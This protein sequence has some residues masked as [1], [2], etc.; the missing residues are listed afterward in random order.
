VSNAVGKALYDWL[1][2]VLQESDPWLSDIDLSAGDKWFAQITRQVREA[3]LGVFCLTS[4]NVKSPWVLFEAGAVMA[5][6]GAKVVPYL[7]HLDMGALHGSPLSEFQAVLADRAGTLKLVGSINAC[8]TNQLDTQRLAEVFEKWWP[9][10]EE[11]LSRITS[12]VREAGLVA[13]PAARRPLHEVMRLASKS[14]LISGHTLDQ[15]TR[16]HQADV[17]NA[18]NDLGQ[19]GVNVTFILLHPDS[20]YCQAHEGFHE[21]ETEGPHSARKQI[22][23]TIDYFVTNASF[24]SRT[25]TVYLSDYMPRFRLIVIDD[26]EC[27]VDLYMYGQD[28]DRT[29]QHVYAG[30]TPESTVLR[31][32]IQKLL[33]SK[34]VVL[35]LKDGKAN[36]DWQSHAAYHTLPDCLSRRCC[37]A[38]PGPAC[39][40]WN[41]VRSTLLGNQNPGFDP[42]NPST[43]QRLDLVDEKYTPGT[44]TLGEMHKAVG[45]LGEAKTYDQWL[46]DTLDY[47]WQ[48]LQHHDLA[49]HLTQG[50]ERQLKRKVK[51]TLVFAPLKYPP[52]KDHIWYQEYTDIVRRIF[53]THLVGNPDF[54]LNQHPSL[55]VNGKE[56]VLRVIARL[57][58][59]RSLTLR[60]WLRFSVIAGLLGVDVKPNHAATSIVL[61]NVGIAV[62]DET[63]I[64]D[65]MRTLLVDDALRSSVDDSEQFC[66]LLEAH[67]FATARLVAVTDDYLE[68]LFLLKFYERVLRRY[69]YLRVYVVPRSIRC[70]NDATASDVR[71]FVEAFPFLREHLG[72]RFQIVESGPKLGGMNMLKLHPAVATLINHSDLLDVRGARNYE[73]MQHIR[74]DAFFGFMVAR[75][76]S[77]I[78]TGLKVRDGFSPFFY[79]FQKGGTTSFVGP[80]A[81]ARE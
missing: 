51:E 4:D 58:S 81:R 27:H 80:I 68:T 74:N 46:E 18:L 41:A 59:D 49:R 56:I 29:P 77:E 40:R 32:S 79:R 19:N 3:R 54:E 78:V 30:D 38:S 26:D 11:N 33:E 24:I 43:N 17:R 55:T 65:R 20:K 1:P 70:G 36:L 44:F 71:E 53:L 60:D 31:E 12:P 22:E 14:L 72:G 75:T 61:N 7:F 21:L 23:T 15:F 69:L 47:E 2:K 9:T 13:F 64:E 63:N 48:H 50:D 10:L 52:L 16:V 6:H 34:N 57:D 42:C 25:I 28:V 39:Q 76:T 66:Q 37:V 67:R 45:F 62:S 35:L 5:V 8:L 73:M